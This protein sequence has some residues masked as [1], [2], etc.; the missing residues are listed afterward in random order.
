MGCVRGRLALCGV[1]MLAPF[2]QGD[3]CRDE[4]DRENAD[5]IEDIIVKGPKDDG[6]E[7]E[8]IEWI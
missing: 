6:A 4:G 5:C 1:V 2:H 7:L 8:D 3:D